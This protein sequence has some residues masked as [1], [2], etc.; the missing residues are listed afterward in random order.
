MKIDEIRAWLEEESREDSWQVRADGIV[1]DELYPLDRAEQYCLAFRQKVELLHVSFTEG[2]GAEWWLLESNDVVGHERRSHRA[3]RKTAV[4]MSLRRI[5][6]QLYGLLAFA[7][8]IAFFVFVYE[9]GLRF[10]ELE[11]PKKHSYE[12]SDEAYDLLKQN[13]VNRLQVNVGLTARMIRITNEGSEVWPGVIIYLNGEDGYSHTIGLDR[14][15]GMTM[16]IPLRLFKKGSEAYVGDSKKVMKVK[17]VVEGY[18]PWEQ[19]IQ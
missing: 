15:P 19:T 13:R 6:R 2:S 3:R 16:K 9:H 5:K 1:L 8:S 7:A 17:L 10:I 12:I 4:H 14:P 11:K 18:E